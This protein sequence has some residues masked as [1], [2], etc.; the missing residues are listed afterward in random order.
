MKDGREIAMS[1]DPNVSNDVCTFCRHGKF[2]GEILDAPVCGLG[3]RILFPFAVE[4]RPDL[5]F[6]LQE[7][8]AAP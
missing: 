4:S 2:S 8:R 5:G 7:R 3:L 6:G 1:V